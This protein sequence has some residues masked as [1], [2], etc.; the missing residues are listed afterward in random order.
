MSGPGEFPRVESNYLVVYRLFTLNYISSAQLI[1]PHTFTVAVFQYVTL[2]RVGVARSL[3]SIL[4]GKLYCRH[5]T[6]R[7]DGLFTDSPRDWR[8]IL[9][10]PLTRPSFQVVLPCS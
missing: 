9:R 4:L 10:V 3:S 5:L 7:Y 8:V 6:A 1:A 2:F